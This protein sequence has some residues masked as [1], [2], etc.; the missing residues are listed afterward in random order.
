MNSTKVMLKGIILTQLM[1]S[2]QS[3][4]LGPTQEMCSAFEAF[5]EEL[6]AVGTETLDQPIENVW[7]HLLNAVECL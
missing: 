4:G 5:N 6:E 3:Q 7:Q 2:L 1:Q